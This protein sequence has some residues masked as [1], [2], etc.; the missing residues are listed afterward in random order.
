MDVRILLTLLIII[1]LC[2]IIIIIRYN[3]ESRKHLK[4]RI[5]F[6]ESM[7]LVDLPIITFYS[8]DTNLV[9]FESLYHQDIIVFFLVLLATLKN[10]QRS[11]SFY[12]ID[13]IIE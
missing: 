13:T 10:I 2:V 1:L 6:K 7:D 5:S 9:S 3:I 12:N 4:N 11:E 8:N